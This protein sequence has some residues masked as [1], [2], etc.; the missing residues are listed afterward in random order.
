MYQPCIPLNSQKTISSHHKL[1]HQTWARRFY[2]TGFLLAIGLLLFWLRDRQKSLADH[3]TPENA[4]NSRSIVDTTQAEKSRT[5]RSKASS[6]ALPEGILTTHQP[7]QL[8]DF[9][10]LKCGGHRVSLRTALKLLDE[11]Y[12]EAC[13]LSLEKPL[14]IKYLVEGE[15]DKRISFAIKEKKW[16]AAL[17]YIAALAGMEAKHEGLEVRLIPRKLTDQDIFAAMMPKGLKEKLLQDLIDRDELELQSENPSLT[18]LLHLHGIAPETTFTMES[19]SVLLISG[20]SHDKAII[21]ALFHMEREKPPLVKIEN[22]LITSPTSLELPQGTLTQEPAQQWIQDIMQPDGTQLISIPGATTA[23]GKTSTNEIK[24]SEGN[25]WTGMQITSTTRPIGLKLSSEFLTEIRPFDQTRENQRLEHR[26]VMYDGDSQIKAIGHDAGGYYYQM[27]SLKNVPQIGRE[28]FS[29]NG[30]DQI[31]NNPNR[32]AEPPVARA[33]PGKSGFVFSPYTNQ[34]V[35]VRD[36]P[37]GV[38]VADPNFP[39]EEKKFFRVP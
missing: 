29:R 16:S 26:F 12:R 37:Q 24:S 30:I 10:L 11:A 3:N 39:T 31:L 14:D 17:N 28:E 36:I 35:D 25:D 1:W 33:V 20:N 5:A 6:R 18:T 9:Y 13:Y 4:R 22:K 38:L 2:A 7:E 21:D 34:L 27:T 15:S 23:S 32:T 19:S 8:E